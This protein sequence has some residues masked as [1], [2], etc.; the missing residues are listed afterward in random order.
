M[1]HSHSS[2]EMKTNPNLK[3][4]STLFSLTDT[5]KEEKT[6]AE[7]PVT[8]FSMSKRNFSLGLI[9]VAIT[10]AHFFTGCAPKGFE[11][12]SIAAPDINDGNNNGSG[13]G[14][15]PGTPS[16]PPNSNIESLDLKSRVDD[17]KSLLGFN[18]ALAF[19]FD[20]VRGEF[21][22]MVPMPNGMVFTPSGA[23]NKYPDIKFGPIFD[24]TGKMKMA[25]RIPVKYV[26]K[27]VTTINPAKLPSGEPLPA[28]PAGRDE[29]PSL[30]LQFPQH[31]NVQIHLY[32]GVNALGMFMTL[33][34]QASLPLPFN[35]TLPLKNQSKTVTY[36][37]LTYVT[38]KN[39]YDAGI[40]VSSLIPP[41]IA[42][43][44]EDYFDL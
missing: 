35:L 25:I 13:G 24:A 23:F 7:R 5:L 42:R 41:E 33:P 20:K 15:A 1:I 37:Y 40:F 8:R 12:S 43:M 21:I 4:L 18:G 34:N 44:L 38:A 17:P 2:V 29:L 32:I 22:I 19:D 9:L 39:G 27:G 3:N 14:S 28:M 6:S 10:V 31:N 11:S 16:T 26:L 36:G 30:A